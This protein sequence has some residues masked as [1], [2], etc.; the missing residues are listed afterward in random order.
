LERIID[1]G[2]INLY[3]FNVKESTMFESRTKDGKMLCI[4]G[5]RDNKYF[6]ERFYIDT[7]YET[8]TSSNLAD[9]IEYTKYEIGLYNDHHETNRRYHKLISGDIYDNETETILNYT[10]LI[11]LLTGLEAD[12]IMTIENAIKELT[13]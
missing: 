1:N 11:D 8:F 7:L 2:S 9:V 12:D 6:I 10:S 13:V 4:G 3:L 5:Y